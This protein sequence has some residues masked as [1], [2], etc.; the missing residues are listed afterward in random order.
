MPTL[1]SLRNYGNYSNSNYGSS[2]ALTIGKLTLFYS[3]ETVVAFE[4]LGDPLESLVCS[5]NIWSNTTGKHL[6]IIEPDHSE[7]IPHAEFKVKLF[8]VL[9]KYD[10]QI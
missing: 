2:R 10:L 9:K 1:I 7:R 3:Y 8:N 5:E 6:N 4:D